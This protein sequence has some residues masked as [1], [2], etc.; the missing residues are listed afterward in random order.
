[1]IFTRSIIGLALTDERLSVVTLVRGRVTHAFTLEQGETLAPLLHAELEA[2][3]IKTRAARICLPRSWAVVK[4]LNLPPTVGEDL[5]QMVAFELERHLPYPI[6]EALY[7]FR[8]GP[9]VK[10]VPRRM[11]VVAVERRIIEQVLRLADELGL[12]LLSI[13]VA[14][15]ALLGLVKLPAKGSHVGLLHVSGEKADLVFLEGPR[16]RLSR[17]ISLNGAAEQMTAEEIRSSLGLLRWNSLDGLWLSGDDA[18]ELLS[19]P[20]LSVFGVEPSSPPYSPKALKA[21][22]LLNGNSPGLALPALASAWNRRPQSNLLPPERRPRR[23]H[24]SHV[25]TTISFLVTVAL[26]VGLLVGQGWQER[27]SLSRVNQALRE[28]E[29]QVKAVEQ[30]SLELGRHRKLLASF[31]DLERAGIQPLLI[32]KELTE[33]I[34]QDAWLSNV[35][36]DVK[37]L[38]LTGQA[39]QASLLIPLLENSPLLERVEFASPVTKGRDKEQFRIRAGWERA[40]GVPPPPQKPAQKP[41]R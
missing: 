38:E 31:K 28:L 33:M 12:R 11:V 13:D 19:S 1:M 8:L 2:R 10:N 20:T 34:P 30:L 23:P 6:E 3:K 41:G 17:S 26:G 40:P 22:P 27:H 5:S 29:P 4:E 21:L 25:V 18:E 39:T 24:W 36:M 35:S 32:L 7:D 9:A 15:H 16:L 14:A 37:G